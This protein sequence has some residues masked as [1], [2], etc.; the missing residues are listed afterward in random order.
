M[1]ALD[2]AA[3][4]YRLERDFTFGAGR[5]TWAELRGDERESWRNAVHARDAYTN[6]VGRE[7]QAEA[8]AELSQGMTP[9][10][11][12]ALVEI[13]RALEKTTPAVR[14]ALS[15]WSMYVVIADTMVDTM[16][17]GTGKGKLLGILNPEVKP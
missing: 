5:K 3:D 7:T 4:A 16:I 1:S 6:D 13:M 9:A 8:L 15:R 10:E 14:S 11:R 12:T 2:R 17:N